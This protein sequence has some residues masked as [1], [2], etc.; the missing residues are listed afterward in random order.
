MLF[1]RSFPENDPRT[2]QCS[3][4]RDFRVSAATAAPVIT[5]QPADQ[6]VTAGQNAAF[7]V[8]ASG[9]P[10]PSFQWQV[11][12]NNGSTWTN[13]N[14]QTSSSLTLNNVQTVMNNNRYRV[15]VSN[16]AGTVNSR[17]A[18][19]TVNA[20]AR[21]AASVRIDDPPQSLE[22]P[23]SGSRT[24]TIRASILD[25]FGSV[26][27][28]LSPTEYIIENPIPTGVSINST[29]GVISVSSSAQPGRFFIRARYAVGGINITSPG[30]PID[31]VRE[32]PPGIPMVNVDVH[33]YSRDSALF[34]RFLLDSRAA[35]EPFRSTFN[36]DMRVHAPSWVNTPVHSSCNLLGQPGHNCVEHYHQ[37]ELQAFASQISGGSNRGIHSLKVI[38][39]IASPASCRFNLVHGFRSAYHHNNTVS[40]GIEADFHNRRFIPKRTYQHEWSHI[41]GATH[42]CSGDC[43]MSWDYSDDPLFWPSVW[44]ER[45]INIIMS[46][47]ANW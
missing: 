41:Y 46:N 1:S 4:S 10:A 13:L 47:R 19:L 17:A 12:T 20:P 25:Q 15:V 6:T 22:I 9:N 36:I 16:I 38:R 30:V 8:S 32:E 40:I 35:A 33:L 2:G 44:C 24:T 28:N 29:T 14:N 3:A 43:I 26:M 27:S 37:H 7:T 5:T 42:T 11:S 18:L 39:N 31:L 34:T 23:N 21:V 45:H